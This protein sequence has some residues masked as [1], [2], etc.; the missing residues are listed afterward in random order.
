MKSISLKIRLYFLT[1][2]FVCPA[3]GADLVNELTIRDLSLGG[4]TIGTNSPLSLA[5]Q[6]SLPNQLSVGYRNKFSMKEMAAASF[7]GLYHSSF[8]TNVLDVTSAGYDDYRQT[9]LGLHAQK[10][11]S[12]KLSLGIA[13]QSIS[14]SAITLDK[15]LWEVYPR[16]GLEYKIS[17]AVTFGIDFHNIVR[18]GSENHQ[19][20]Q[21]RFKTSAGVSYHLSELLLLA[22]EYEWEDYN[23]S[24][25]RFGTEYSLI[26]ELKLRAGLSTRPFSPSFGIGY[27]YKNW[28]V[29]VAAEHHRYLGTSLSIGLSYHLKK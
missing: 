18:F 21:T 11:L 3:F 12:E 13:L 7:L 27:T 8:M 28:V 20:M 1:I 24:C 25:V 5:G 2:L 17:N 26:S 22:S 14:V 10:N 6:N 19:Q 16:L 4:T 29:D 23:Q 9:L 15:S